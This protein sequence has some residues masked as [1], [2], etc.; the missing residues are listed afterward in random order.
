MAP[1]EQQLA[2]K[3]GDGGLETLL[4]HLRTVEQARAEQLAALEGTEKQSTAERVASA[5]RREQKAADAGLAVIEKLLARVVTAEA[6]EDTQHAKRRRTGEAGRRGNGR[7]E[8]S[9]DSAARHVIRRGSLVA[10][11]VA[12]TEGWILATV[13]AYNSEKHRYTVQDYDVE[14]AERPTYVLPAR[15]VRFVTA[16]VP[17]RVPWDRSRNPEIS[18][19]R[20]VL[21]LYPRTTVFYQC[22][23]IVPPSLNNS[24]SG[25]P[26][27]PA[28]GVPMT[29]AAELNPAAPP[30][31]VNNPM[32]KVRFDDD[33]N[34]E[35]D[36]PA[37]LVIPMPH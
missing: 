33:D 18:R 29:P 16:A 36:V 6:S 3:S 25:V 28:P 35:V 24:A 15:L 32:Y 34:N 20:R 11:S 10:A 13:L 14:S 17:R 7:R 21:A 1:P 27:P 9:S 8:G 2:R 37:H 31:P 4:Q 5:A 26:V 22:V 19:G 30:D 12:Q 23:V